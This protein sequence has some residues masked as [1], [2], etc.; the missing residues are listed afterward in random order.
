M[1]NCCLRVLCVDCSEMTACETNGHQLCGLCFKLYAEHYDIETCYNCGDNNICPCCA[2]GTR[3]DPFTK[4]CL[5][6]LCRFCI[7]PEPSDDPYVAVDWE[8]LGNLLE[9]R[10]K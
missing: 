7:Q 1:C 8:D 4:K 2:S 9:R 6:L 10:R 5:G 3:Q